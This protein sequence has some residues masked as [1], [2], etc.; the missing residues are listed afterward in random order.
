MH[1]HPN[2]TVKTGI[3][4]TREITGMVPVEMVDMRNL[5]MASLVRMG[6]SNSLYL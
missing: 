6:K 2:Q 4:D 3:K 1:T 5:K